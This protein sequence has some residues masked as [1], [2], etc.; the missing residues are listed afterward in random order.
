MPSQLQMLSEKTSIE[1]TPSSPSQL[2]NSNAQGTIQEFVQSLDPLTNPSTERKDRI[3]DSHIEEEN[4]KKIKP[5]I[6]LQDQNAPAQPSKPASAVKH[7]TMKPNNTVETIGVKEI[8]KTDRSEAR[9]IETEHNREITSLEQKSNT[10][11]GKSHS[12][13]SQSMLQPM[14]EPRVEVYKNT[15]RGQVYNLLKDREY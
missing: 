13:F 2:S 11:H 10:Q 3:G 12:E 15:P 9:P 5:G 1:D 6:N 7:E 4:A 14:N 8:C